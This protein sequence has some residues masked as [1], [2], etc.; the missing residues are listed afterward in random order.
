M[1]WH[2]SINRSNNVILK[3]SFFIGGS[4]LGVHFDFV[5]NITMTG[6]MTADIGPRKFGSKG[7]TDKEAC[8]ALCSFFTDGSPCIDITVTNNIAAGCKFA[9]F[10]APG[11]DCDDSS[12]TKFRDNVSHSNLGVGAAIYPDNNLGRQH[13]KCYE[14]SHFKGYKTTLPCLATHYPTKE[15]RAHDITCI[16]SQKGINLQT[17]GDGDDIVIKLYDS[18][19]Y[20]ET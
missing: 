2:V 3:D 13:G 9:G 20:G 19:I 11:H 12:S 16:D 18:H 8:V 14:M 4:Q 6:T 7:M 15:M 10:I 17:A 1:A 5:R